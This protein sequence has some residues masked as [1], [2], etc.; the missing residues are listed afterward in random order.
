MT[1]LLVLLG[2][3]VLVIV[4]MLAAFLLKLRLD[5]RA[6]ARARALSSVRLPRQLTRRDLDFDEHG[7]PW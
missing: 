7:R 5:D 2:V 4:G 3:E 1:V 6:A